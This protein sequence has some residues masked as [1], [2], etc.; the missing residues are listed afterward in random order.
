MTQKASAEQ[1]STEAVPGDPA[2]LLER[3]QRVLVIR[4]NRPEARNAINGSVAAGVEA[5]L[6]LLE[7]DGELWAGVLT[8]TREFFC[9]GAD[10]KMISAGRGRELYTERGGFGGLVM[11]R[12]TKPLIVAVEGPALAGGTE[13]C[14]AADL[15][16]ASRAARFGI[17]E[18]K[19]SLVAAA[20]GLYRL[21]RLLPRNVALE[22]GLTGDPLEAERAYELGFVNVLTAPGEALEGALGLA[23]RITVNAPLAV[24]ATL[25][26]MEELR[27][28]DDAEADR[29]SG[30]AMSDL[31]STED[32][33]EGPRAFLEKRPP[34]WKG[35]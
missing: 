14:L 28:V 1:G 24:Q 27:G 20:G 26:L 31:S 35:R 32:Y 34:Q 30:K 13:L 5:G 2:V 23:G 4:L 17:P 6:D 29:A 12:R 11:R 7:G 9:A 3:R 33:A 18:V 10:L 8:G 25:R 16:V 22:L 15:V 21:P 19:R